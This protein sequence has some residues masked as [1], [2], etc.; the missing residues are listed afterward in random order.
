MGRKGRSGYLPKWWKGAKLYDAIDGSEIYE[1]DSNTVVQRGMYMHKKNFDS[2]TEE[3]RQ[4]S[5][6][7]I[8]PRARSRAGMS[9]APDG[10]QVNYVYDDDGNIVYDDD[11]NP[12]TTD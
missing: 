4:Q 5:I 12:V 11:G 2:L 7:Q 6:N 10:A 9:G 8:G 3:Q 1:L